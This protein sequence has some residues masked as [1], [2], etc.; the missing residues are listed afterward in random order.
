MCCRGQRWRKGLM[1][2]FGSQMMLSQVPAAGHVAKWFSV[3][4]VGSGSCFGMI[5]LW[6]FTFRMEWYSY[7]VVYWMYVTCILILQ[8]LIVKRFLWISEETLDSWT[9]F[10]LGMNG[11]CITRWPWIYRGQEWNA[12]LTH[13]MPL[14]GRSWQMVALDWKVVEPLGSGAMVD[15]MVYWGWAWGLIAQL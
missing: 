6:F 14:V 15:E 1:Q 2:P 7:N 8:G 12:V 10:E 4:S 13:K 11:F 3:V 9:V 5:S